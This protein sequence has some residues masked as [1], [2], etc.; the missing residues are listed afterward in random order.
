M[1]RIEFLVQD[2]H[3]AKPEISWILNT[4]GFV[5]QSPGLFLKKA[6]PGKEKVFS[7]KSLQGWS[8]YVQANGQITSD[9]LG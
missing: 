9:T 1:M 8:W 3:S 2:L 5:V 4:Q 7:S 6:C